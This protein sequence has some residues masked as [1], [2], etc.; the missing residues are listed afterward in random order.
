MCRFSCRNQ[1]LAMA[2]VQLTYRE[3]LRNIEACLRSRSELLYSL[4]FRGEVAR[5]TLAE[6]N[7]TRDWRICADLAQGLIVKIRLLYA[8][9]KLGLELK[10]TVYAFD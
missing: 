9:E 5:S 3:S 2:F 10:E 7:K 1:F 6:T 4:G 8:N